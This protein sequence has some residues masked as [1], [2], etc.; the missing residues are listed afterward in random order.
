MQRWNDYQM[1]KY[2][3]IED[4]T[5]LRKNMLRCKQIITLTKLVQTIKTIQKNVLRVKELKSI[6]ANQLI[7]YFRTCLRLRKKFRRYGQGKL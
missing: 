2:V 7:N 5:N 6:R 1:K 3:A 4:Y